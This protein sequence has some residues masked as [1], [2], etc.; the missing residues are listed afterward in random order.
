M[1]LA[2][3][4]T[5]TANVYNPMVLSV[6]FNNTAD[7]G[8]TVVGAEGASLD[9]TT[10]T[11]ASILAKK[12]PVTLIKEVKGDD[13]KHDVAVGDTVPFKV[14]TV[15]PNYGENYTDPYFVLTDVLSDGLEMTD[16]QQAAITVKNG[17]GAALDKKADDDDTEYDYS[18]TTSASGYV[19]T[20]SKTFL[21]TIKANTALIVEYEAMCASCNG[22]T[23][24]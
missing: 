3:V 2:L 6:N 17:T 19:I 23:T 7:N 14:T 4:T 12:Q 11:G 5:S 15:T 18:I 16:D 22:W 8:V 1:Y 9:A 24:R 10:T 20:F 21:T 13:K